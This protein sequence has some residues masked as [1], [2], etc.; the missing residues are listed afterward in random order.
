MS[1]G[2]LDSEAINDGLNAGETLKIP[3]IAE[4]LVVTSER[5]E[6]GR[7][8]VSKQVFEEEALFEGFVK[9]EEVTVERKEINQYVET[10]PAAVRQEGDVTIISVI[11]EV[12]VVEKRLMLVEEIHLTKRQYQ[13]PKTFS[14]MLRKEEVTIDRNT[15]GTEIYKSAENQQS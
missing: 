9:T 4:K 5:I 10:A 1:I 8:L 13:D 2:E 3:V 14:E 12:L 15:S 6:T 11:K 7:V